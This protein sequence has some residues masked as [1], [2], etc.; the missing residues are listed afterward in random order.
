MNHS[1]FF[2]LIRQGLPGDTFVLHGEEEYVKAQAVKMIE[3]SYD[4]DLRP[5][6]VTVLVK[7]TPQELIE[8]CEMLPLFADTR[9]VICYELADGFD[10]SKYAQ[11]FEEHPAETVLLVVFKGKLAI[12]ADD[13]AVVVG[14]RS[15]G[16]L[17]GAI[18]LAVECVHL[19]L[20]HHI[21]I[22]SSGLGVNGKALDLYLFI[23]VVDLYLYRKRCIH[24]A[25]LCILIC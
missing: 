15:D 21:G 1:E 9:A 22:E 19:D 8:C 3:S 7:P 11:S 25:V 17:F 23:L 14:Y 16:G 5:F 6:N 2:K 10:A 4:D 12:A 13:L 18:V 20:I 24:G